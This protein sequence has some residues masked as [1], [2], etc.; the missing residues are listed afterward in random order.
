MFPF[1]IAGQLELPDLDSQRAKRLRQRLK[2]ELQAL[3]AH[4]IEQR[5]DL[6]RFET[7]SSYLGKRYSTLRQIDRG[8]VH[9][10]SGS[11]GWIRYRFSCVRM[12]RSN[13]LLAMLLLAIAW[14][15]GREPL[16]CV[17]LFSVSWGWLVGVA[18]LFAR[19]RMRRFLGALLSL[20]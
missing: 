7:R 16:F 11:P 17:A 14:I 18:F 19:M 3:Q 13:S 5:G 1:S 20:S 9:I 8:T 6:T 12:L 10:V 2:A 4:G 15:A